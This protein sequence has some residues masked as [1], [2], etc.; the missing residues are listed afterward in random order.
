MTHAPSWRC[1]QM[2][3]CM[4][5][6]L[7]VLSLKPSCVRK[8][9]GGLRWN[10]S[11][12]SPLLKETNKGDCQITYRNG[13][14]WYSVQ[15][16]TDGGSSPRCGNDFSPRVSFQCRLSYGVHTAPAC[17]VRVTVGDSGLSCC[18]CVT[19]YFEPLINSLVC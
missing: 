1:N 7:N 17:Q 19:R 6:H 11:A 16:N 8:E 5:N 14:S 15:L 2:R 4:H 9:A 3:P 13:T 12:R 18:T 10:R